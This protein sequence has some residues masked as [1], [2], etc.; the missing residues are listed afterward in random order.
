MS[1]NF[2]RGSKPGNN[3]GHSSKSNS[4]SRQKERRNFEREAIARAEERFCV[5]P[6]PMGFPKEE[7]T[8]NKINLKWKLNPVPHKAEESIRNIVAKRGEYGWLPDERVDEIA[9]FVS[10]KN[11]TLEQALSLRSAILQEKSVKTFS[12]LQRE[13][14]R[15]RKMYD[16]G[17]SVVEL[18]KR[19]DFPPMNL[20][21]AILMAKGWSKKKI[22]D[23]LR[24]PSKGLNKRD[25]EEFK[26]AEAADRVSNVDQQ[27]T[28]ER[29]DVFEELLCDFFEERGVRFRKQKEMVD[30]QMREHGRPVRTPDLLLLDHVT[31][32]GKPIAWIDAKHYYGASVDFQ[33]RKTTKQMKRYIEEWGMGAIVFRHG[34]SEKLYIPGTI[35][36]DSSQLNLEKLNKFNHKDNGE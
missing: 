4:M 5:K 8:P 28:H 20:F 15:I 14:P 6:K 1:R 29:A 10:N 32:N 23:S 35:L 24:S 18:S 13:A 30:E 36:L 12:R 3:R 17:Q 25:F 21:R 34:F 19:L 7:M 26:Q 11:I 33:R 31:I 2:G 16:E 22:K 27:E 9:K